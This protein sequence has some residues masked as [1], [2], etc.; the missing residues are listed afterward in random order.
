MYG[1]MFEFYIRFIHLFLVLFRS[2]EHNDARRWVAQI[3][4]VACEHEL[5]CIMRC[6]RSE[7][8]GS[9]NV[10]RAL[11]I[12]WHA[13]VDNILQHHTFY[14]STIARRDGKLQAV[15]T[16]M[17]TISSRIRAGRKWR[18]VYTLWTMP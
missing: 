10:V 5:F 4:P 15:A 3:L 9:N 14:D 16:D 8:V 12:R 11:F 1:F 7:R 2:G 17:T 13:F 18:R 6:G